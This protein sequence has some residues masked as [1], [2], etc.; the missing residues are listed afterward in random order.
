MSR[1]TKTIIV[2]DK[3]ITFTEIPVTTVLALFR[4]DT[5]IHQL[6]LTS[7]FGELAGLIPLV[8]DCP[9]G[10]LLDLELY[11]DD[12]EMIKQA[13][14]ETNPT[15]FAVAR[16]LDLEAAGSILLKAVIGSCCSALPFWPSADTRASENTDTVTSTI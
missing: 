10:E 15:F 12:M 14:E 4:N 3:A 9:I 7:M 2:A 6:P 13:F 16:R 5:P 11:S 8:I 1:K